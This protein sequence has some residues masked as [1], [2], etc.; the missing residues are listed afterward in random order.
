MDHNLEALKAHILPLSHS[1]NFY[2]AK[3]E[4]KLVGVH[5]SDEFDNC[6]CGQRIK[7]LCFIKNSIT[8]RQTYVGNVCVNNFIGI[9]TGNLFDGLRRIAL[10]DSANANEYLIMHAYNLGYI[11]ESE[12]KFLLSTRHKRKLAIKQIE[13]KK[14][15]NHRILAQTKVRQG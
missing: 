11:Y 8:K 4:W 13:W 5:I 3:A 10:D 14:K 12:Y 15:I 1:D 2:I 6:P 7:E 9:D